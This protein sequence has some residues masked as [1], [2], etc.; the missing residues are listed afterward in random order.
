[1]GLISS[2][3]MTENLIKRIHNDF[4]ASPDQIE[5]IERKF[6]QFYTDYA[7]ESPVLMEYRD[8]SCITFI[9][10]VLAKAD[11]NGF[12]SIEIWIL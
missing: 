7:E 4:K 6:E 9:M 5:E 1:M 8:V 2:F 3:S 10:L 11:T 12:A